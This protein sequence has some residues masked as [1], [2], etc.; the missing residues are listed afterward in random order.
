M[1]KINIRYECDYC[2]DAE[3]MWATLEFNSQSA[4]IRPIEPDSI[5]E[6]WRLSYD[7]SCQQYLYR[8]KKCAMPPRQRRQWE[9]KKGS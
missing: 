4:G 7:Y 6:G 2:N 8:C 3:E 9:E 1:F 5:P